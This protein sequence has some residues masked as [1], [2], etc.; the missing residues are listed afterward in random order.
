MHSEIFVHDDYVTE[1]VILGMK[2]IAAELD[3]RGAKLLNF[4]KNK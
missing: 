1:E 2:R 3:R 4:Y